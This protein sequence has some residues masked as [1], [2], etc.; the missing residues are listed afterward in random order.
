MHAVTNT[1]AVLN[2][3][4]LAWAGMLLACIAARAGA[5]DTE[6]FVSAGTDV[7]PNVL[8]IID[9]STSMDAE[10]LTQAPWD[11][12][13]TF[14]GC[15]RSDSVY[16]STTP[17]PPDCD[18]EA[19]VPKAQNFCQASVSGLD[20]LGQHTGTLLAWDDDRK[21][22]GPLDSEARDR[23]V[24]CQA[25]R[26]V[27]G[28]GAS[29]KLFAA[30][31]AA[32]PWHVNASQEPSW[33]S[34]YTL[35][36]GNWLNWRSSAPTV[37]RTRL[38]VVQSVVNSVVASLQNVN[39]GLMR[40]NREDGGAVV[41]A[42]EDVTTAR[43]AVQDA[44][45]AFEPEDRTPLTE[46]LYEAGLYIR[47][48]NVDYGDLGPVLSV[49][50]SRVG[51]TPSSGTY[52][53]PITESCQ[54]NFIVLLT[55]GEPTVDDSA[56]DKIPALPGFADA[57][58]PQCDG[59][60]EGK[61]LDDMA[62]YLF[63]AD[64]SALPGV[65]NA[66]TH[67]IGFAID[68]PLLE[69][70]A[71]RGG[72]QYFLADD[73]ASLASVLTGL[74]EGIA[75]RTG[76]FTAPSIP[77]N[78]FNRAASLNDVYVSLFEPTGTARW[79]G[80]LKKYR[81]AGGQLV[82]QD[83]QPAVDAESGF[84]RPTAWSFWS[85]A[86]D[87]DRI[88]EG[89][90]ASRL[91][92]DSSRVLLTVT[93]AERRNVALMAGENRVEVAN[94]DL[95]A[96]LLGVPQA[97]RDN[98]IHWARGRD[99]ADA[100][101]DGD[102]TE[103]RRDM[104]D[105]LHVRPVVVNY[106]GTAQNSVNVVYVATNDGYLHAINA[107]DGTERWAFIPQRLLSRLNELYLDAPTTVRRY[108][109]DGELR[110]FVLNDDG[111]PGFTGEN[112]TPILLFG[113]GR[114]GD[115][116]FALD[117]ENPDAPVLLWEIDSDTAGYAALGQTWSTPV[118]AEVDFE[119]TRQPVAFFGGG[120]D[121]GQ[122]NRGFRVEDAV[123]NA[124][125]MANLLTGERLWSAGEPDAGHDLSLA[126]MQHSIP[127]PVRVLDISGDG[128]ADRI[129]T[130]DMGGRLWRIDLL[131]GNG[132]SNFAAGGMLAS[133]GAADLDD[134]PAS[135]VRRFY[136]TPDVVLTIEE[137]RTILAVNIGSGYRGHPLDTDVEDAFFSVRDS[138]VFEARTA[139]SYQPPIRVDDLLDITEDEAPLVPTDAAGWRLRMVQSPGEK[140]LTPAITL[141]NTVFFTSF[142]PTVSADA[143]T[144]GAGINRLYEVSVLDGFA[145]T[146]L[147]GSTDDG[148]LTVDDRFRELRQTNIAPTPAFLTDEQG[149]QFICVGLE[150]FPLPTAG[151]LTNRT[152]WVQEQAE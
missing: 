39:V 112:E 37:T 52:Q 56:D 147:D 69:D 9:T 109:L 55:D 71:R 113:M 1:T 114:G 80:N 70:T 122:D 152:F 76:T 119:G 74:V 134:P 83:E 49:A 108:G 103:T 38:E 40:F 15:Y 140:I 24:E 13:Q 81:F 8:F 144:A 33:N 90:A 110:L 45:S 88:R 32:G 54:N 11:S 129:Y 135:E 30:D 86:P 124:V 51:A 87:G 133:L 21:V 107:I 68:L 94:D 111:Q 106:G 93:G 143:C 7:Q 97:E 25:D 96:A 41:H 17:T 91:P 48:G 64:L 19:H 36:D 101:Q 50:G 28:D 53:A 115:A 131:N 47:G 66:V 100:D 23:P 43:A 138:V 79:P 141:N 75:E 89:G 42:L 145:V 104:G 117:I 146:N 148:P 58:G 59:S 150:C 2:R 65:Q 46:A 92:P 120:Y 67:V 12:A 3:S 126:D 72:G 85:A 31:G 18:S 34:Q 44:V 26:G 29:S 130:G 61:C 22:W 27:H 95:T 149:Q 78:A 137:R 139:A 125:F 6:L 73:S 128:L 132:P 62:A 121:P 35:F 14:S 99:V 105:P 57:V 5:D 10:V 63:G 84:F 20:A 4:V 136:A 116:V 16:F 98:L 82:G 118:P 60:G 102:T 77:V 123:G 151:R 127:A 142:A